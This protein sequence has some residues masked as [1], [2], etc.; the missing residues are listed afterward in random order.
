MEELTGGL[1][2]P[3][4]GGI[5]LAGASSRGRGPGLSPACEQAP[6]RMTPAAGRLL[7]SGRWPPAAGLAAGARIRPRL[8]AGT[9]DR[10][11]S[12]P[13][14]CRP[15]ARI[16]LVQAI[17]VGGTAASARAGPGSGNRA[18]SRVGSAERSGGFEAGV[19]ASRATGAQRNSSDMAGGVAPPLQLPAHR[20]HRRLRSGIQGIGAS[21]S[22][23]PPTGPQSTA[24]LAWR[25]GG[26]R[27]EQ[28]F[29]PVGQAHHS[30]G[31]VAPACGPLC[32]GQHKPSG[33]SRFG[34]REPQLDRLAVASA[35][36]RKRLS[37]SGSRSARPGH[38][39]NTPVELATAGARAG[40]WRA[41]TWAMAPRLAGPVDGRRASTRSPTQTCRPVSLPRRVRRMRSSRWIGLP[42]AR[43]DPAATGRNW[44]A[45][46]TT[47]PETTHA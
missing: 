31:L 44:P 2:L 11:R 3:G 16:A 9:A 17:A 33:A 40:S 18:A 24:G 14:R 37:C 27:A 22:C 21:C 41:A 6:P 13:S 32:P 4:A 28:P 25:A 15:A 7:S 43:G 36:S 20:R 26:R 47:R 30:R 5:E 1:S 38:T 19:S 34:C 39:I 29:P 45:R 8:S 12:G 10:S 23:P 35:L 42:G 46:A